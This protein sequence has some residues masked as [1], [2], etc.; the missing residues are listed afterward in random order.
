MRQ[1]AC[2]SIVMLVAVTMSAWPT[3]GR[4]ATDRVP[5]VDRLAA[6]WMGTVAMLAEGEDAESGSHDR[7]DHEPRSRERGYGDRE[8]RPRGGLDG[9][10]ML[11][12]TMD[13]IVARLSRIEARLSVPGG[14]PESDAWHAPRPPIGGSG[15]RP[16][17]EVPE[18]VRAEMRR[19]MEEGRE[20]MEQARRRFGEM[21][22]RIKR[23]EAE[24]ERLKAGR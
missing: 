23:L 16:R 3:P 10:R 2:L 11:M 17:G 13:D 1:P 8:A 21:E 7:G 20:R 14:R 15:S 6:A 19:R 9:P 24:V 4:A 5:V 22:E 12:A 18:E